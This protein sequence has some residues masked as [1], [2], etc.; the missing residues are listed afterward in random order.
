MSIKITT[1]LK[2][3]DLLSRDN[4]KVIMDFYDNVGEKGSSE[5]QIMNNLKVIIEYVNYLDSLITTIPSGTGHKDIKVQFVLRIVVVTNL[6]FS[7]PG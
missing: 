5:N 4:V 3:I 1:L 7:P 6:P 2:K